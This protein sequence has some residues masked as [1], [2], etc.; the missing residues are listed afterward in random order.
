MPRGVWNATK[1]QM[2]TIG[3]PNGSTD[4]FAIFFSIFKEKVCSWKPEKFW[5][6]LFLCLEQNTNT[7][8]KV[9]S[10][11]VFHYE[12]L[13]NY[14][15]GQLSSRLENLSNPITFRNKI[16]TQGQNMFHTH[17]WTV[18][19]FHSGFVWL[20]NSEFGLFM[21]WHGLNSHIANAFRIQYIWDS[22]CLTV[23][24]CWA[25]LSCQFEDKIPILAVTSKYLQMVFASSASISTWLNNIASSHPKDALRIVWAVSTSL[26]IPLKSSRVWK[27]R[28]S[29]FCLQQICW[30]YIPYF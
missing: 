29:L 17:I 21:E 27:D 25:Q 16:Y 12:K 20:V 9:F 19:T 30:K 10:K 18:E 11:P 13:V 23:S 4:P 3:L 28:S 15:T 2:R 7:S 14:H 8:K 26:L 6:L 24:L 1:L 22:T 5:L